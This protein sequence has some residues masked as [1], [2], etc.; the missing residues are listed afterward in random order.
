MSVVRPVHF[1]FQGDESTA[2]GG[3][4]DVCVVIPHAAL[5]GKESFLSKT[6]TPQ[7][8]SDNLGGERDSPIIIRPLISLEAWDPTMASVIVCAQQDQPLVLP[9]GTEL[10]ELLQ[11]LDYF[12]LAPNDGGLSVDLSECSVAEGIRAR[13]FI[14][15]RKHFALASTAIAKKLGLAQ[16][17]TTRFVLRKRVYSLN[18]INTTCGGGKTYLDVSTSFECDQHLGW[19]SKAYYRA[20]MLKELSALGLKGSWVSAYMTYFSPGE[21]A[22]MGS[23]VLGSKM[24]T[25]IVVVEEAEPRSKR[26]RIAAASAEE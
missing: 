7:W 9:N 11:V 18:T 23:E 19:S 5:T 22:A 13:T 16:T 14:Q 10:D 15:D 20:K 3:V 21:F 2:L 6:V 12:Q 4:A 24:W 26:R 25:L 1:L 8:N 17:M